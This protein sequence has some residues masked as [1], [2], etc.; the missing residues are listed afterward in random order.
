MHSIMLAKIVASS[1]DHKDELCMY[2]RQIV[3]LKAK[4]VSMAVHHGS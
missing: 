2:V 4:V 3:I 1:F